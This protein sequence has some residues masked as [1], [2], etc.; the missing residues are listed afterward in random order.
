MILGRDPQV[1]YFYSKYSCFLTILQVFE[2]MLRRWVFGTAPSPRISSHFIFT[3][4]KRQ[5]T[6]KIL[7]KVRLRGFVPK[8]LCSVTGD[9]IHLRFLI[10]CPKNQGY[11]E[12]KE[13]MNSDQVLASDNPPNHHFSIYAFSDHLLNLRPVFKILIIQNLD[14]LVYYFIGI[15]IN[16]LVWKRA[17]FF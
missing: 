6:T 1:Y 16:L 8:A 12:E 14:F 17:T 15:L 2:G 13:A 10:I 3:K 11:G 9:E 5:N 7:G 4:R